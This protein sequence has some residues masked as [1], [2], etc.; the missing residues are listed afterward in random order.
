VFAVQPT[1]KEFAV[2]VGRHGGDVVRAARQR[3]VH[4]GYVLGRDYGALDDAL[5]VAVTEKRHPEEIDRLAAV[6]VEVTASWS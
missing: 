5:L 4:P 2:R 1:F 6:L 3:G